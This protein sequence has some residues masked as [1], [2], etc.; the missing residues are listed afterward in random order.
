MLPPARALIRVSGQYAREARGVQVGPGSGGEAARGA[1]Y[2]VREG[3]RAW[4]W[5]AATATGDE[6]EVAKNMAA[7]EHT[8]VMQGDCALVILFFSINNS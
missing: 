6:R 5:C 8:L 2:V 1:C 4:V 3:A 7:A